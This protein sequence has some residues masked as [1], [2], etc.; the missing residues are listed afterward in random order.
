M[1]DLISY[2]TSIIAITLSFI[3]YYE[4]TLPYVKKKLNI[5]LSIKGIIRNLFRRKDD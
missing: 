5:D 4:L 3:I 1:N 2:N